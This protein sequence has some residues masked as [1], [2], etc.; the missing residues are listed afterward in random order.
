MENQGYVIDGN[1][2]AELISSNIYNPISSIV[3]QVANYYDED[4]TEVK[5]NF[6]ERKDYI[7]EIMISGDGE[8]FSIDDLSKLREI[9]NSKK[10]EN[11]CTHRFERVKLGSFGIAFVALQNLGEEIEIY[12]KV[13]SGKILYKKIVIKNNL[14]IF[15]DVKELN[16]CDLIKYET[17]CTLVIKNCKI[18]KSI[19]FDFDLLENKLAYLPLSENF[20]IYLC[21]KEIKRFAIHN[22]DLYK[23]TFDFTIENIQ[24]NSNIYYYT[25]N[26]KNRYFRGVFLQID[27]RIIDWNIYDG[28]KSRITSPIA[29]ETKIQGYIVAN[30]LRNK[31]NASRTGLTDINLALNISEILRKNIYNISKQAGEYYKLIESSK[32]ENKKIIK[33]KDDST[34]KNNDISNG[35][36]NNKI[37]CENINKD[38]KLITMKN[39][40]VY[41]ASKR[42]EEANERIKIPN[43]DLERLGIKFC[44]EPESEIE[45]I[46]IASQMWQK[47]LLDFDIVQMRSNEYPDSIIVKDG[48]IAFLEFEKSLHDFYIHSHNHNNIDYILCWKVNEKELE[49]KS[50]T[51]LKIYSSYIKY[52]D[53]KKTSNNH[54]L[55]FYNYDGTNHV[56][57]IYVISDIIKRI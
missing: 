35:Q 45:V 33:K 43:K 24:F 9:G 26:V 23:M 51:Y 22:N 30:E 39:Q 42:T 46:I 56:V 11:M 41:S 50:K 4:A 12:S 13:K 34:L 20:K 52:I 8:G 48:E 40:D 49:S 6:I 32:K 10:R 28:I 5:I 2:A 21:D 3:E 27:E 47:N 55:I 38:K 36:T 53:Y 15:T 18:N 31:I 37:N 54:E 57:K 44:Y 14:P 25:D 17:G 16:Y 7:D 19:L 1:R 29:V